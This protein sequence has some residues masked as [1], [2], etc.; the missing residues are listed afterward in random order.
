M[1]SIFVKFVTVKKALAIFN[2][3]LLLLL[4]SGITLNAHFCFGEL[5]SVGLSEFSCCMDITN[6]GCKDSPLTCCDDTEVTLDISSDYQVTTNQIASILTLNFNRVITEIYIDEDNTSTAFSNIE[7]K[8]K[9]E[10]EPYILYGS[11]VFY[12]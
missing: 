6:D 5:E 3:F 8:Q 4:G 11:L 1:L 9:I 12:G 7:N 10:S 2:I